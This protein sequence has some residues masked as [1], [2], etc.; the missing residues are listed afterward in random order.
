MSELSL[1]IKDARIVDGTGRPS[2]L[3]DVGVSGDRIAAIGRIEN[4]SQNAR[5][6]DAGGKVLSPGFIDVHTHYDAQICWD[7]NLKPSPEHGVTSLVMGNC[8]LSMAPFSSQH[9]DMVADMF[10]SVEDMPQ[11]LIKANVPFTWSSFP[12]YLDSLRGSLGPNVGVMVGHTM[13]RYFVMGDDAQKRPAT[14]R[15]IDHMAGLLREAMEAGAMGLSMTHAH[16]DAK[17]APLPT[18]YAEEKETLALCKAMM[19]SGRGILE[20]VPAIPAQ[21]HLD[22]LDHLGRMS[23]ETG[24]MATYDA[25]IYSP[26]RGDFWREEIAKLEEWQQKG[27]RLTAQILVR[28]MD[29][30]FSLGGTQVALGKLESW[31]DIMLQDIN[32]RLPAFRDAARRAE[33]IKE[34]DKRISYMSEA[35]IIETTAADNEQYLG[36]R[37]GDVA[38]EKGM[39]PMELII[40]MSLKEDLK[41][42]F[43]VSGVINHN[44]DV[45]AEMLDHPLTHH[46]AADAGA[47]ISQFAGVGDT[48]YLLEHFV[49]TI[50]KFSLERGVEILTSKVAN[51]WGL[52]GRGR[53]EHGAFADLVVFDPKTIARG[54]ETRVTD[55]PGNTARWVRTPVG[56]SQV[57]VNGEVLVS[58][59]AYTDAKPGRII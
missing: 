49:R 8:S 6:I 33:M 29:Q 52:A 31:K 2:Y 39:S 48:S 28:S 47:H 55:Y 3:G 42:Q 57:V 13:L 27:A 50:G 32:L 59:R 25:I 41:T 15:E 44:D 26:M 54:K 22:L 20:D 34:A 7:G 40:D 17:G 23:R 4:P 1:V 5:I 12:E 58:E 36:R 43:K 19:K 46:G 51:D 10:Y 16:M 11:D 45:I 9:I 37:V 14:D 53:I 18:H 56:I 21:D 30:S 38:D 35:L 24:V